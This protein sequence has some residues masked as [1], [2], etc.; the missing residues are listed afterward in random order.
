VRVVHRP[1]PERQRGPPLAHVGY[2]FKRIMA[3]PIES[4]EVEADF[5]AV[6]HLHE[7]HYDRDAIPILG[8]DMAHP[9]HR[10]A[11]LPT[12]LRVRR[13]GGRI[14]DPA[15]GETRAPLRIY[16]DGRLRDHGEAA[17]LALGYLVEEV[18]YQVCRPAI[19]LTGRTAGRRCIKL[20]I[21]VL[22]AADQRGRLA[23]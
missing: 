21:D 2:G 19:R 17:P 11:G 23:T 9:L 5:V 10:G 15:P 13:P 4:E 20:G 3:T 22:L 12:A 14:H 8:K 16:A 18:G 1:L 6:T 7:D